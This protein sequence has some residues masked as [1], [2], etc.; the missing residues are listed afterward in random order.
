MRAWAIV[1]GL[2]ACAASARAQDAGPSRGTEGAREA[3]PEAG[4]ADAA[5]GE[6]AGSEGQAQPAGEAHGGGEA[7]P[8][9]EDHA[10]EEGAAPAAAEAPRVAPK[11]V[12]VIAGD[13]D[14]L[15]LAAAREIE[16][17]LAVSEAVRLPSDPALRATLRG[18]AGA[19]DDGLEEV[20]RERRRLGLGEASDAPI[21]QRLGRRAGAVAVIVVRASPDGAQALAL[22]VR[23][24]QFFEGAL[25]MTAPDPETI[26]P[27]VS[28]RA[29]LAARGSVAAAAE[30]AGVSDVQDGPAATTAAP[31]ATEAHEDD[32]Q[33][34]GEWFEENWP[35]FAAGGLL[36]AAIVFVAVTATQGDTPPPMLRFQ[37]GTP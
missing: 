12:V 17:R 32:G 9:V 2:L 6:T 3:P 34:A 22:D 26:V 25:D 7:R 16:A 11:V 27:F 24:A 37:P 30:T 28:R 5:P 15:L 10:A 19:D 1:I 21:L 4:A 33:D 23:T 36:A 31:G 13:P 35:Y 29:R 18:E 8:E 20:R 14:P